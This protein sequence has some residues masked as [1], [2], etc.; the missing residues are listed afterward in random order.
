[1]NIRAKAPLR[2]SFAGGGTD[3]PPY[4][5]K[6]GGCVLN[7][8]IDSFAWGSLRPRTDETIK[9]TS[10]DFDLLLEYD[11]KS[12]LHLDGQLDLVKAV[13]NRSG[14][15]NSGG[16]EIF[17]HSDAPPGSGLGSSSALIVALVGLIKEFKNIRMSQYEIAESAYRIERLDLAIRGG[18]QDQYAASFGGFNFME[19]YADRVVVNPLRVHPEV[20]NELE[21]NLLL[22]Y[23]GQTRASDH[24]IEDQTKRF[25]SGN[26]ET[27]DALGQQKQLA[28]DMKSALLRHRLN[29][30]GDLLHCAWEAKRR[31]S[32]KISNPLIE[33]MYDTATKNGALGGKI[34]GAGGGGFIL[35]Y[36]QFENK[37]KIA[38]ALRKL[39]AI[40]KEFA[41]EGHGLQTWRVQEIPTTVSA[42]DFV[43]RA[44][45]TAV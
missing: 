27:V 9:L 31:I 21:H 29:D 32:S 39:G 45:P 17:L 35:F 30:F 4:P 13:I 8:T 44:H 12:D 10:A 3:V 20:L 16:F 26:T 18:L 24:I 7:A 33:E 14:A 37:L 34:T 41:F 40:P 2:I 5:E 25:E 42:F 28:L 22:C 1:M 15:K 36:C 23:T 43:P 38:D 19:F 6:N 11:T